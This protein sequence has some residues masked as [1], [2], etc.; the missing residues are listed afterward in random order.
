MKHG[1]SLP[2]S[3]ELANRYY[4]DPLS[5]PNIHSK[6]ILPFTLNFSFPCRF[7]DELLDFTL[8]LSCLRLILGLSMLG[9]NLCPSQIGEL[10]D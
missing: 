9:S 2:C 6:V 1:S 4:P 10:K 3:Q 5:F 7:S 8:P